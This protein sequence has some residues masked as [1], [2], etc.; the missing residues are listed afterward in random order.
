MYNAL[1]SDTA[2]ANAW[3][4]FIWIDVTNAGYWTGNTN[5]NT[6]LWPQ[7]QSTCIGLTGVRCG[8]LSNKTDW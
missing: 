2:C 8:V 4:K 6:T 3:S 7:L 5:T 1:M